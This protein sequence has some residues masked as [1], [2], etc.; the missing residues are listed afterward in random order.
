MAEDAAPHPAAPDPVVPALTREST[1][2]SVSGRTPSN[3]ND[4]A[5]TS[6]SFQLSNG[7]RQSSSARINEILENARERAETMVSGTASPKSPRAPGSPI[8]PPR[9]NSAVNPIIEDSSADEA[10]G[11][12]AHTPPLNYNS[13][14]TTTTTT[15]N[16]AAV[17]SGARVRKTSTR[18][19]RRPR[20]ASQHQSSD[21]HP[22]AAPGMTYSRQSEPEDKDPSWWQVQAEKFQS[23]ELENKGSVA[24]DHLAIERTFLAWL[25]TS[26]SFAS[27]GIAVT[28]LFR[29]NTSLDGGIDAAKN[30]DT[31]RQMGKP[32]GTTFLGI[33]ILTLFLGYR[34]YFQS[35]HW[36]MQGKFPASRGTITIVA[37]V[38]FA[39]M[40]A[41]LV[42]V[43][44]IHPSE[45]EL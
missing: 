12:I 24:R 37:F 8:F 33:S 25:R 29:L 42:V 41:S 16:N 43:I 21:A 7:R 3:A 26:L 5:S 31:L 4:N 19:T 22:P 35:Q 36:V 1:G 20:P 2:Q 17:T 15:T 44:A 30:M 34:R 6:V 11:F 23:I 14:T 27:I 18:S 13:V 28:Q 10:T 40:V 45:R 39:I 32:L 9:T 38:A